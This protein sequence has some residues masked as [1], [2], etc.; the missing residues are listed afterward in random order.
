MW[1]L[2]REDPLNKQGWRLSKW[3]VD[4]LKVE[5]KTYNFSKKYFRCK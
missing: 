2:K 4:N 5:K 3:I 1:N